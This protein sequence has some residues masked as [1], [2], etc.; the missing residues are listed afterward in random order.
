V[1]QPKCLIAEETFMEI[2][3]DQLVGFDENGYL[4]IP[5]Y[6]SEAEVGILKAELPI[7]YADESPRRIIEKDGSSIR[8]VYGSHAIN[9]IF[10]RLTRHPRLVIP[11]IQILKSEIYIYQFK[12]NAKAAFKGDVWEWHQDFIFWH[13]EDGMPLPRVINVA[14][15]LDDVNE[16]NGPIFLIP[17]SH[18]EGKISVI[19]K[20]IT[21][22]GGV[23][24]PF[25]LSNV[26]ANLKYSLDQDTVARFIETYG[27]VSPKGP[28]GSVL[29]FH[30]NVV[31]ASPNNISPFDR[32]IILITYNSLENIPVS[33]KPPRP[34][35]LVSRDY[36]SVV[37]LTD[38]ALFLKEYVI[39]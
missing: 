8:S 32:S 1:V 36:S 39:T 12:I 7:V 24:K 13:N 17:G 34:D 38:D 37:P 16:F 22:N 18:K 3:K 33:T 35:F 10:Y 6:F 2:T 27:V 5:N 21:H 26:T 15:F 11:I 30:S 14:L 20:D 23:T 29:F 19:P 28:A 4:F 31:H 9:E 25:W